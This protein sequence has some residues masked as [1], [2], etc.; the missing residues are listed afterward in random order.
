[1]AEISLHIVS[2]IV[3]AEMLELYLQA[4]WLRPGENPSDAELLAIVNGSFRFAGL[5]DG[6]RLVGMGRALS[7]GVSDAYIQDVT[8]L[9]AYRDRGLGQAII[10]LL[11]AQLKE[12]GIAWIGLVA[13]PGTHRFYEKLGF[14]VLPDYQPMLL[15][16]NHEKT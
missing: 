2:E 9:P 8:V 12:A 5:F 14:Q 10:K 6:S 13:E 4:G 11:V 3:P 1:M 7:D 15:R 16:K